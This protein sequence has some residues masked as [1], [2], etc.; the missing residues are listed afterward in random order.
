MVSCGFAA[1]QIHFRRFLRSLFLFTHSSS[2][3]FERKS[4][5]LRIIPHFMLSF[6][7]TFCFMFP[8]RTK[9]FWGMKICFR[10]QTV[11][12]IPLLFKIFAFLALVV[13]C[14]AIYLYHRSFQNH[15]QKMKLHVP[16]TN[17]LFNNFLHAML[18]SDIHSQ[19]HVTLPEFCATSKV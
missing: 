8:K 10:V 13:V 17:G 16:A 18:T 7:S 15:S 6:V 19:S 12:V 3:E 4:V 1:S 2:V 9:Q 5:Q 14:K 11:N